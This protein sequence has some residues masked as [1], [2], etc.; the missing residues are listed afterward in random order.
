MKIGRAQK[1]KGSES[2]PIFT[3]TWP[4][5][6]ARNRPV[7]QVRVDLLEATWLHVTKGAAVARKRPQGSFG[8]QRNSK[9]G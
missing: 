1:R 9:A 3:I 6:Y 4:G 7:R 8:T 5:T 2:N